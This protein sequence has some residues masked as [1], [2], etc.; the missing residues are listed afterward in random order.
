MKLR[1]KIMKKDAMLSKDRQYRYVLSR[2]WD[3]DKPIVVFIGLNPSTADELNDDS[4]ITKCIN[5]AKSWSYGGFYMLNLFAYRAKNPSDMFDAK[6]PIGS[7][8]DNFIKEY[9]KKSDKIVCAWGDNGDFKQ[10]G[11]SVL[12]LVPNAYY[13]K[14]NKSGQPAHP[15]YLK[16]DFIPQRLQK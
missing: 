3:E 9:I 12:E 14:L 15:L 7:E 1:K 5:Y 2:I 8:N 6:E 11:E 4:T 16:S 10:R 13:L